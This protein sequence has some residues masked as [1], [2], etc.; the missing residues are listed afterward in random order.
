MLESPTQR[1]TPTGVEN[2]IN[3]TFVIIPHMTATF[4]QLHMA[5]DYLQFCIKRIR[6]DYPYLVF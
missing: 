3:V 1:Y 2:S 4:R 6:E 5:S